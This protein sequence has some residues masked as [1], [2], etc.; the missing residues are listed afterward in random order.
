MHSQP[1]PERQ[2][3]DSL[4]DPR[5]A[6]VLIAV[7]EPR[8]A[9]I[10]S[11]MGRDPGLQVCAEAADAAQAVDAALRERP[12][13]CVMEASLPGFGLAAAWEITARLPSVKVVMLGK[14]DDESGL[15]GALRAGAS[16]YLDD[17]I[18]PDALRR[19]LRGVVS[20][21]AAIRRRLVARMAERFRES[22]PRWRAPLSSMDGARLTGREWE[23]LELLHRGLPTAEVAERLGVSPGTIRSHV[24]AI[25]HKLGVTD[26]EAALRLLDGAR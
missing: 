24:A 1:Q 17:E 13:V 12:D 11:A 8:R 5:P 23:V 19:A 10:R 9:E 25:V 15:F 26:R 20:G 22:S 6:R 2:L 7:A 3:E 21:E 16:G 4:L 14:R 18:A